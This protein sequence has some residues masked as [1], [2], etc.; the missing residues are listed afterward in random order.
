MLISCISINI[1]L[2]IKVTCTV[3]FLIAQ[4]CYLL[5]FLAISDLENN[6]L[7]NVLKREQTK[8]WKKNHRLEIF[9]LETLHINQ[10]QSLFQV[11]WFDVKFMGFNSSSF[12]TGV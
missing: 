2:F 7:T 9:T 11:T 4:I 3:T 12:V 5:Q 6:S 1:K 10:R 8:F